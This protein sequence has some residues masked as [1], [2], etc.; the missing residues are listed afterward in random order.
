MSRET[1]IA[2]LDV[3]TRWH[4]R[5]QY[6]LRLKRRMSTMLNRREPSFIRST[7]I[8]GGLNRSAIYMSV[9]VSVYNPICVSLTNCA[10]LFLN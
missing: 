3:P 6:V 9:S 4:R 8:E 7:K 1:E 2:Q 5:Q 10:D